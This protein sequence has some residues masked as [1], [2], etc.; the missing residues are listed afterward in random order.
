M[1][2]ITIKGK[3]YKIKFGYNS[4]CDTDLLDRASEIMGI[5]ADRTITKKDNEFTVKMFKTTRELLFEGFKKFN[6]VES[7]EAVGNLLDDYFDEGTEEDTH[8]L[9][10]V[11]GIVAQELLAEG[12]FGDLLKKSEKAISLMEE[13]AKKNQKKSPKT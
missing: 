12:F 5:L 8:G 2:T 6:P 10:D 4:F 3:E 11:F 7:I 13:R 9:M 1:K